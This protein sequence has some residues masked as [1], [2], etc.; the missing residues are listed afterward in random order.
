MASER[1]SPYRFRRANSPQK[2][3]KPLPTPTRHAADQDQGEGDTLQQTPTQHQF[4]AKP[5]FSLKKPRAQPS[6][7]PPSPPRRA[8]VNALRASGRP[9]EDVEEQS[10]SIN[11][12]APDVTGLTSEDDGSVEGPSDGAPIALPYSPKRRR[13]GDADAHTAL[14]RRAFKTLTAPVTRPPPPF[15][16]QPSSTSTRPEE[17]HASSRP[18]FLNNT[19]ARQTQPTEPL[20]EAFS[21]HRRGQKFLPGGTASVVQQWIIEAGQS[22]VQ[23]RRAQAYLQGD[24]F[25]SKVKVETVSGD[26]PFVTH[27]YSAEGEEIMLLLAQNAN[28]AGAHNRLGKDN[29]VG[30]RAPTWNVTLDGV[31]CT[32]AVDWKVLV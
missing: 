7:R 11:D 6:S 5:R 16:P 25:V 27:A 29:V 10:P 15:A 18:A 31:T 3:A 21:P 13:L 8:L 14:A 23:S 1:P 30:I 9:R 12:A 22:A 20:P 17:D 4:A 26:G 2:D 24:D 28:H 19:I 32:I